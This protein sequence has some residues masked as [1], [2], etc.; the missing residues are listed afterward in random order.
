MALLQSRLRDIVKDVVAYLQPQSNIAKILLFRDKITSIIKTCFQ[1]DK[2]TI[3]LLSNTIEEV[4][5]Q[6]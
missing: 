2:L 5:H 4:L 1:Q 6:N 3:H